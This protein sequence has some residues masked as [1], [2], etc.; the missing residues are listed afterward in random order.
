MKIKLSTKINVS[1]DK[2]WKILAHDFDNAQEW[3]AFIP[4][5]KRIFA[6]S[7]YLSCFLNCYK[8]FARTHS[9]PKLLAVTPSGLDIGVDFPS[10]E[11]IVY[12]GY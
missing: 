2:V 5:S 1:A 8:V 6:N 4:A 9:Y 7:E 3:M 12:P 10:I 11:A